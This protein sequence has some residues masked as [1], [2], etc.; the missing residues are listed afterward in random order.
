MDHNNPNRP[1]SAAV[2]RKSERFEDVSW[3]YDYEVYIDRNNGGFVFGYGAPEYL[4]I[5]KYLAV[6]AVCG[7]PVH[8]N[9][10]R[11]IRDE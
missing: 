4:D 6:C 7:I 5:S 1:Y 3:F 9:V 8:E 10:V 2:A 11:E